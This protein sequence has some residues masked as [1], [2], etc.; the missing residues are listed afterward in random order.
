MPPS[1][2]FLSCSSRSRADGWSGSGRRLTENCS[3]TP[4][5]AA[6]SSTMAGGS[7]PPLD[8]PSG[9]IIRSP[10]QS[11]CWASPNADK[12]GDG[13]R[14]R[15]KLGLTGAPVRSA[16]SLDRRAAKVATKGARKCQLVE[17]G[18]RVPF[19]EENLPARPFQDPRENAVIA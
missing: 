16:P 9:P 8:S 3:P 6:S 12:V 2:D 18:T 15:S 11:G 5:A 13:D 1:H 17:K 10:S 19:G 4:G 7:L 14:G